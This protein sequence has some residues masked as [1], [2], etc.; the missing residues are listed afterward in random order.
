MTKTLVVRLRDRF[1]YD[2]EFYPPGDP[3]FLAAASRIEELE[4]A[5]EL[6]AGQSPLPSNS[7]DQSHEHYLRM[8]L[9]DLAR[10]ALPDKG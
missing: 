1:T 5:L 6:I 8:V 10:S 9:L 4:R 2:S 3:I 7:P